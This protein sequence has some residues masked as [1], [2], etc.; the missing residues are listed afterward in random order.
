MIHITL[1]S[2][3]ICYCNISMQI[4]IDSFPLWSRYILLPGCLSAQ[5]KTSLSKDLSHLPTYFIHISQCRVLCIKLNLYFIHNIN[6]FNGTANVYFHLHSIMTAK[7]CHAFFL[8]AMLKLP[9]SFSDMHI[10]ISM[11]SEI[12]LAAFYRFF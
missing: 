10:Y 9:Q 7:E 1:V 11:P 12:D 2:F 6:P 8:E 4:E 5:F 3:R